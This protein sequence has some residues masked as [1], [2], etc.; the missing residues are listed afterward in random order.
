MIMVL[1]FQV[2]SLLVDLIFKIMKQ[3][4]FYNIISHISLIINIFKIINNII[5]YSKLPVQFL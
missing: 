1:K 2:F 3:I 5:I 4:Y